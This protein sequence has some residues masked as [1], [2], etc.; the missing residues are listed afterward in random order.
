[1]P[2]GN[3]TGPLGMGPMT[4]RAAGY[5]AG[6]GRP[7]FMT[8]GAGRG[9][10]FGFRGGGRGRR[11]RGFWCGPWAAAAPEFWGWGHA[12][13][14]VAGPTRQ[15]EQEMLQ[16]Q[17]ENLENTLAELKQRLSELQAERQQ[18]GEG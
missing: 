18:E 8:P 15:Q 17:V 12:A 16:G 10:G 7:G 4:G 9:M 14:G 6:F 2:A 13:A 11:R 3:G 1:M 5:C